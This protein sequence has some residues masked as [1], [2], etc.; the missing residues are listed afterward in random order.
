MIALSKI[1]LRG[2]TLGSTTTQ[3]NYNQEKVPH[4]LD[5]G[6]DLST[7]VLG[8]ECFGFALAL[9]ALYDNS[10]G[11]WSSSMYF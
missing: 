6:L 8:P 7:V 3:N 10:I 9:L 4:M 5:F 11:H 1:Q 2:Y